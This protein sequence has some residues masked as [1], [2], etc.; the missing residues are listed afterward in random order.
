MPDLLGRVRCRAGGVFPDRGSLAG[1][2][3]AVGRRADA[4]GGAGPALVELG[5]GEVGGQF[6]AAVPHRF[7]AA[8]RVAG[9]RDGIPG[10][11][12]GIAGAEPHADLH[13]GL[14]QP[15]EELHLAGGH[16]RRC[17]DFA[18]EGD[19]GGLVPAAAAGLL[20]L[21]AGGAGGRGAVTGCGA[22]QPEPAL[23]REACLADPVVVVRQ[24]GP[25][26]VLAGQG[27]D[28]VNVVVSVPDGDPPD[29]VVFL[30]VRGQA[31]AVH[32][33]P[34][35]AS[36]LVVAEHPV[37]GGG[38]DRAMP[39][40]A[41][42]RAGAERGDGL[43]EQAVQAP[44]VPPAAGPQWRLELGGVP[45][46]GD[47]VRVGVLGMP[48]R[49]VEVVDEPVGPLA[50]ENLSDHGSLFRSSSATE[51]RRRALRALSAAYGTRSPERWP[52]AFSF[53]TA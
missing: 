22:P 43:L 48:A 3:P 8:G 49:T 1:R 42:G 24:P 50:A 30:P 16:G 14:V 32:D 12:I 44:E 19:A 47:D 53:A 34:G 20:G 41:A 38:S 52:V 45:P 28:D 46:P 6:A 2:E 15:G 10:D 27:R 21:G 51:S 33:L 23:Y 4:G 7:A 31:G 13:P 17:A 25:A 26:A 9:E 29:R 11:L 37:A 36:P 40:R 35:D 18:C 5:Q 39:D